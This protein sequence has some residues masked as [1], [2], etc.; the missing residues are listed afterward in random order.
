MNAVP[1]Q[2]ET[3]TWALLKRVT[4]NFYLSTTALKS[5]CGPDF[6]LTLDSIAVFTYRAKLRKYS[7]VM[8]KFQIQS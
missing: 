8:G 3:R 7:A 4:F 2:A 5:S 1:L 6:L